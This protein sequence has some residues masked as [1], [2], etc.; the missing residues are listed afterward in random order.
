M[1]C[2]SFPLIIL[3]QVVHVPSKTVYYID[4][5]GSNE[6]EQE[7]ATSQQSFS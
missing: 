2:I 5:N 1:P 7:A 4:P 6:A 3:T